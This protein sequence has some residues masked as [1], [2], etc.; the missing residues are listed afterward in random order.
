MRFKELTQLTGE[1]QNNKLQ[2][3]TLE[4]IKLNAQVATGTPPKNAGQIR[5]LKKDF[6]RLML[7]IGTKK[8]IDE[9]K[10]LHPK[11]KKPEGAAVVSR[12]KEQTPKKS[13][14][15]QANKTK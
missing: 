5:K 12:N 1:E 2:E 6:A 9:A 11:T 4:L 8:K 3:L 13:I 14:K 10:N 7:I 15:K